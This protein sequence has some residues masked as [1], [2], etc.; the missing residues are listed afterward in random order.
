MREREKKN[1]VTEISFV[2][3]ITEDNSAWSAGGGSEREEK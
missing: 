3:I 1:Q 2:L